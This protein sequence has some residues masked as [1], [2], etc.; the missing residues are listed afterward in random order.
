MILADWSK[1]VKK[2]AHSW[3]WCARSMFAW[4]IR[5]FKKILG[6]NLLYSLGYLTKNA[7]GWMSM[8]H[9]IRPAQVPNKLK[10]NESSITP[11]VPYWNNAV[12]GD[13][14][15]H[16]WSCHFWVQVEIIICSR[17]GYVGSAHLQASIWRKALIFMSSWWIKHSYMDIWSMSCN[18][19]YMDASCQRQPD[20]L[21]HKLLNVIY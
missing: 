7:R 13:S 9:Q 5:H 3:D 2:V 16:S 4:M 14:M 11:L 17:S 10:V 19:Q 21:S 15:H 12:K 8:Q 20:N 1:Q 18:P 6:L